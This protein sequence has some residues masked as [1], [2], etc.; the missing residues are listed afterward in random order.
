VWGG[1]GHKKGIN[2]LPERRIV[3]L[4]TPV[5]NFMSTVSESLPFRTPVATSETLRSTS[6][7]SRVNVGTLLLKKT[8]PVI[9]TASV[10]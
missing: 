8:I 7:F 9:G 5:S 2:P 6:Q 10:V 3:S 4:R 1:R